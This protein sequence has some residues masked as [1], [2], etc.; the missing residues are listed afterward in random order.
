[1]KAACRS[2]IVRS[3][4][5][6]MGHV[7]VIIGGAARALVGLLF[8]SVSIR[9]EVISA[10]PDFRSRAAETLTPDPPAEEAIQR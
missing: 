1:M 10:S 5:A 6:G 2:P 4:C 7:A 3:G 9:I 8:V